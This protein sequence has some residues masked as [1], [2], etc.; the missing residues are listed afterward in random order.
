MIFK[1]GLETKKLC[2]SP[3]PPNRGGQE[4]KKKNIEH[5]KADSQTPQKFFVCHL[6]LLQFKDAL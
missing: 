2:P 6:L 1:N 4:L 3:L 5:Y